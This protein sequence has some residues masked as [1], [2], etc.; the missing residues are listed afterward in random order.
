MLDN[1]EKT[2]STLASLPDRGTCVRELAELGI[3]SV[4]EICCKSYRIIYEVE[5]GE[6]RVFCVADGRRDMVSLLEKRI[7]GL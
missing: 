4:W 2:I 6:V 1:M 5:A 7:L 3:K